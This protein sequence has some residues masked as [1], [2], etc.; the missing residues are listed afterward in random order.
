[1]LRMLRGERDFFP[2]YCMLY[3]PF[4]LKALGGNIDLAQVYTLSDLMLADAVL[5]SSTSR[6]T[7][8]GSSQIDGESNKQLQ[9][10]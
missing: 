3:H 6:N 5:C 2:H 9:K 10:P 1:M 8:R 7:G 4:I